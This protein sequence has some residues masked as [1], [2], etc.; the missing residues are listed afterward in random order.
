M[1]YGN[2]EVMGLQVL[3]KGG[4]KNN[5]GNNSVCSPKQKESQNEVRY[6]AML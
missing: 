2:V 1:R 6:N 3:V 4:Q 5:I